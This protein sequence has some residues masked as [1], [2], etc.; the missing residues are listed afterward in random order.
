VKV[1]KRGPRFFSNLAYM[2]RANWGFDKACL[3]LPM[4][5]IPLDVGAS[6]LGLLLPKLVLDGLA[7]HDDLARLLLQIAICAA[8]L[9]A[10]KVISERVVALL[11]AHA[12]HFYC[13][14]SAIEINRQRMRVDYEI[15]SSP[16]GKIASQKATQAS[17]NNIN[18]G[19][20]SF[21]N[22]LKE[23]LL[24]LLGFASFATILSTLHPL[25]IV[26][27]LLSYLI[28]GT[29]ALFLE[30]ARHK[31]RD[32][33]AALW[34]KTNYLA[35]RTSLAAYAKDIR[36]YTLTGWLQGLRE[37]LLKEEL[38]LNGRKERLSL[39]QMLLEGLLV[40]M[41]DG[42]AYAYLTKH[43]LDDP[44]MTIGTFS[45]YFATIA[46]FGNWLI[47][48]VLGAQGLASAN[49]CVKDF[50]A[51]MENDR[52]AIGRLVESPPPHSLRLEHVSYAYPES[53][54]L[55]LDDISLEIAAGENLAL[56]GVNGAGK[57]T[58]V[59]LLCG[60]LHP[61]QGEIYLDDV[62]IREFAREDY[63][64]RFA[65]VFQDINLLPVSLAQNITF[66]HEL[67]EEQEARLWRA[68]E[69]AGLAEHVRQLPK[70]IHTKLLRQFHADGV[71]FSGGELQKLLLARAL[72]SNAPVLILDEP[73]AALDPIAENELYLKYHA[74]TQGK[75][76]VYISHRLSST[77]FCDRVVLL[78][79]AKLAESGTHG[80]LMAMGGKYAEMFVVSSKYY[81]EDGKAGGADGEP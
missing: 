40:F 67:D 13:L 5:Q 35:Q 69:Q 39:F 19:T 68:L 62:N 53:E 66:T 56:V 38:N 12:W 23:V 11:Q 74:L 8:L 52:P 43:M 45:V 77:R 72:Y 24:N 79:G 65:A 29:V 44:A 47:N 51:F 26:Y 64:A 55:V 46:G 9:V 80:E 1:G 27:L 59:K 75:T 28:D 41:R 78:D 71:D 25:I 36:L 33:E 34:R 54:T 22:K 60:L 49:N 10:L 70:E 6:L 17:C 76:S 61:T 2:W 15:F 50:R 81:Q 57:T 3:A 16:Q 30:R 14:W 42:L 58:L 73:T 37:G 21:F 4:L 32:P 63:F 7:R 18:W 48:L 20:N 31:L